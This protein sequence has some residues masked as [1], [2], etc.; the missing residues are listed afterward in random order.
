MRLWKCLLIPALAAALGAQS[1]K[2]I[3][4]DHTRQEQAGTSAE[5]VICTASEPNPSPANPVSETDW[6]GGISAWAFDLHTAGYAIQSLPPAGRITYGDASNAQDLSQYAVYVLPEPYLKFTA[7]EKQAILAFVQ[8]GGGLFLVGNHPGAIRYSG[9]G[10]TDAY[11]AFNDLVVVNG[12]NPYGFTFVPGH[13]PGDALANTTSTLFA[14][15]SGPAEQAII[16]G[17]YGSLGLMDFHSY[18]YLSL[19]AAQNPSVREILRTQ[20]AGDA[21]SFIATC[22]LGAGRVVA[23]SDSAP[24]DDGT[25]TTAGKALHNSYTINSNK[26]FFLNATAYLAGDAGAAAPTPVVSILAPASNPTVATG[27]PLSFQGS[28]S[29]ADGSALSYAWAFG[30]GASAAVQGPVS[31]AY[32]APGTFTATFTATSSQ[33]KTASATRSVTVTPTTYTLTAT[34]GTGGSISPGG[35]VGVASGASQTFTLTPAAGYVISAVT[36]DGVNKGALATYTFNAVTANHTIAAT[37]ATSP[38]TRLTETFN[39]GTKGAYAVGTVTLPTGAWTLDDALLGNTSSDRKN[40]AQSLRVRNSGKVTMGFT[41]ASGARTVSVKHAKYGTD[42][43][44][45]WTLW[46]STN[47][48]A[49]WAQTG[50]TVTTSATTLATATFT[51]NLSGGIRFQL[52]KTD[53]S[54]NRVNFDDFVITGY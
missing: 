14:T 17:A 1:P 30:D 5:W 53:G 47:G 38:G 26:A 7:A 25:T 19:D 12:S 21:G 34:A 43:N 8:N 10:G 51:V 15:A 20:V 48:G 29:I 50:G 24:A 22:T 28:A 49:S 6:N 3:L 52:R 31:H 54:A 44:S 35:A 23:I 16:Q 36:V 4:F 32:A 40:G 11:T 18:S 13:G 27:T 2:R 33:G 37:F 46:Y 9:T 42:A 41:F 39:T 45:T